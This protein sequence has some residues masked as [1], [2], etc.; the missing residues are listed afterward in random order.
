MGRI[1]RVIGKLVGMILQNKYFSS[2]IRI[3]ATVEDSP[4]KSPIKNTLFPLR[5]H[6]NTECSLDTACACIPCFSV[7]VMSSVCLTIS[8]RYDVDPNNNGSLY[9]Q[10]VEG[11][12]PFFTP[13]KL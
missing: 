2:S 7:D 9:P 5:P 3:M 11:L 13:P 8:G 1:N 4:R 12:T 10:Y 6:V